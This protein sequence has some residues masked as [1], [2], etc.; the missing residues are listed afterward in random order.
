MRPFQFTI[1]A[2]VAL[3]VLVA[4]GCTAIFNASPVWSSGVFGAVL[5]VLT[6]A[7]LRALI[8]GR[9]APF[10]IGL[11]T[12]GWLYFL[13]AIGPF[14]TSSYLRAQLPTD[15][16]LVF[17]AGYRYEVPVTWLSG[18]VYL[19]YPR[20]PSGDEMN[21]EAFCVI[22]HGLITLVLGFC[23]GAFCVYLGA[24]RQRRAGETEA[25]T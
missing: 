4:V 5:I 8:V 23:G 7:L 18:Q 22:G 10:S 1:R 16:A 21:P 25:R 11:A 17:L 13:F 12:V 3:T 14:S 2:L 9:R 15:A 24:L 20:P 19:D 6:I